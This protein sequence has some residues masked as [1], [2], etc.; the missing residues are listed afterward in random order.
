MA[1]LKVKDVLTQYR[2]MTDAD[3]RNEVAAHRASLFDMR[4]RN[5]MRQ[6]EDTAGMR[7]ARRNMARALTVLR[8]RE[9]GIQEKR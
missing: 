8:E 4:R 5:S 7:M 3:L 9:L 2:N 1:E 6:L